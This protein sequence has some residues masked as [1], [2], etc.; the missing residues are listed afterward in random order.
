M[1]GD[2]AR[3]GVQR[4]LQPVLT[5]A[6]L[7]SESLR[8]ELDSPNLFGYRSSVLVVAHNSDTADLDSPQYPLRGPKIH[9]HLSPDPRTHQDRSVEHL[10]LRS[11]RTLFFLCIT[12]LG[13]PISS[14]FG[15]TGCSPID[16]MARR[17]LICDKWERGVIGVWL[18]SH[19]ASQVGGFYLPVTGVVYATR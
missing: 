17:I 3:F 8:S 14:D 1:D 13:I 9:H 5:P 10:V 12:S 16:R 2:I 19:E 7:A 6:N 15:S 11:I 18:C 4:P